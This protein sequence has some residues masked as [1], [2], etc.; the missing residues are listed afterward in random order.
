MRGCSSTG[1]ASALQAEGSRFDPVHLHQTAVVAQS[2]EHLIC[3]Q[4][5]EGSNPSDG[6]TKLTL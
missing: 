4:G 6:T 3:N 5:V 1:R 2:V